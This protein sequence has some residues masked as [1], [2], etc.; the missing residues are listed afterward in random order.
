MYNFLIC[1]TFIKCVFKMNFGC[2]WM[3]IQKTSLLRS[4][5]CTWISR[6]VLYAVHK[7]LVCY[8]CQKD[9]WE[10]F[11]VPWWIM[12]GCILYRVYNTLVILCTL[13]SCVLWL[14]KRRF[15]YVFIWYITEN[16][17]LYSFHLCYVLMLI[18][19]WT[20]FYKNL[21]KRFDEYTNLWWNL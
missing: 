12:S 2:R 19:A 11:H 1:Q 20:R 7:T 8:E 13:C 14:S 16:A 15:M 6:C 21:P 5:V 4:R 17:V 10:T 3:K 9:P 18:P